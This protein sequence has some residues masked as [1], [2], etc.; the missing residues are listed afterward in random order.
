MPQI[1]KSELSSSSASY[2]PLHE[3]AI[4]GDN[5]TIEAL[6]DA[7]A[8]RYTKDHKVRKDEPNEIVFNLLSVP[9]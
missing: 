3:A 5:A 8:D 6:L 1:L 7:G 4:A 9:I 2:T